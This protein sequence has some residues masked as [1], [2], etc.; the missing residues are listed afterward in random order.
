MLKHYKIKNDKII[1]DKKSNDHKHKSIKVFI[2][3]NIE[4]REGPYL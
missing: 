1:K 4:G 2:Y 3:I